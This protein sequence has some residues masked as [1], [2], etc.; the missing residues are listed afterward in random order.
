MGHESR[1]E[2]WSPN[3]T[4]F[5]FVVFGTDRLRRQEAMKTASRENPNRYTAVLVAFRVY[6]TE[7]ENTSCSMG[8]LDVEKKSGHRRSVFF[9]TPFIELLRSLAPLTTWILE[10]AV[11]SEVYRCLYCLVER[12]FGKSPLRHGTRDG[13]SQQRIES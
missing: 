2:L 12:L 5:C 9:L 13:S 11:Q 8:G 3:L 4:T 10:G 7:A 1:I 6:G